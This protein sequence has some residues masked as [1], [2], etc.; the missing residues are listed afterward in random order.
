MQEYSFSNKTV[1]VGFSKTEVIVLINQLAQHTGV[2]KS[3]A[4]K[5][6]ECKILEVMIQHGIVPQEGIENW[7]LRYPVVELDG[8]S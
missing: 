8:A 1:V 7:D 5:N 2:I 4:L 3:K 6:A